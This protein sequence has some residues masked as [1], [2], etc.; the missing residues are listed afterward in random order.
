MGAMGDTGRQGTRDRERRRSGESSTPPQTDM[1]CYFAVF[2]SRRLNFVAEMGRLV[3]VWNTA[4]GL[5]LARVV[6]G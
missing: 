1:V 5:V 2:F 6:T 4:A 3:P